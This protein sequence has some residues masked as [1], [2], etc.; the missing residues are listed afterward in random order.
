MVVGKAIMVGTNKDMKELLTKSFWQ[1]VKK[2]FQE[3]LVDPAPDHSAAPVP[4]ADDAKTP[5]RSDAGPS[6]AA[7]N[8][9]LEPDELR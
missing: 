4:A 5:L 6:S 3:A 8:S 2:T 9:S 7:R 1:G